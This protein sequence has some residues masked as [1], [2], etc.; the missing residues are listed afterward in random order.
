MGKV[1]GMIKPNETTTEWRGCYDGSW[2]GIIT[3]ESFQHPAKFAPGLIKRILAHGIECG[4]WKKG[5]TLGD[6]FGGIA[7]GGIMAGFAGL[8][9]VGCEL[10]KDFV[11]MGTKNLLL[12]YGKAWCCCGDDG[13][14]RLLAMRE[15]VSQ[16][17][18]R[19]QPDST[20]KNRTFLWEGMPQHIPQQGKEMDPC[21]AP[22]VDGAGTVESRP[23]MAKENSGENY[24]G[25]KKRK[26]SDE[27]QRELARRREHPAGRLC[28]DS[29]E[30]EAKVE[31]QAHD[32]AASGEEVEVAAGVCPSQ[33]REQIEQCPQ[34]PRITHNI[35]PHE[36][37][38]SQGRCPTCGKQKVIVKLIQ[39]DSRRFAE[40]V[41]GVVTSPPYAETLS[42]GGGPVTHEDKRH[43][44]SFFGIKEG[45]GSTPGQIG[46]LPT[47]DVDAVVSSPPY[48]ASN[49]KPTGLGTG[50]ASRG[51]GESAGRNKGDYHHPES[52][53]QIGNL[54]EGDVAAVVTSPPYGECR[55]DGGGIAATG[56]TSTNK[57]GR[58]S[59]AGVISS[60]PYANQSIEKSSSSIDIHKNWETYRASGGGA[61]LEAY[62]ATQAK[63]SQGYGKS[64]GQIAALPAG[65]LDGVATSPP[66]MDCNLTVDRKFM[67]QVERDKRN[68]S[69]L[70]PD[71]GSY[72]E[73]KG[74]IGNDK[75][76]TYWS[77]MKLVYASCFR[78]IK[79]GAVLCVV[80]KDFVKNKARVPLCD[81]TLQLLVS[82]GFEPVE[83]IHAMLVK[84]TTCEGLFAPVTKK[85]S[86]KSF[87]RRLAEKNGSPAIDW[88]EVLIVR[89]P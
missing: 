26:P 12:H 50:K 7:G 2:K 28:G 59:L 32:G 87:F 49:M 15:I 89:K 8:N 25:G 29:G 61:S 58:S 30:R 76:E 1:G 27:P 71:I 62:A 82:L 47:G 51:Q 42:H 48:A 38:S 14:S 24:S 45:Y 84:E 31:T 81:Q 23:E 70:Q 33:R 5:D 86:R 52:P 63:R 79:P 60:P 39:G 53:G 43:G 37:A 3:D 88:E 16:K 18:W 34:Q 78:A 83:R 35:E 56:E 11:I 66:F 10:E 54:K 85:T 57:L 9:W 22:Q 75:S 44:K 4:Y 21:T 67:A 55:N 36:I 17:C 77:A 20:A 65:T 46:T 68:G 41:A 40:I 6:P 72:G 13:D 19:G 73:S 69:R 74:Q 80:V 64:D